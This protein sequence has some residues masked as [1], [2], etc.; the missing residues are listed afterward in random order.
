MWYFG[1]CVWLVRLVII[2]GCISMSASGIIFW[3]RVHSNE[4]MYTS[5][6][7]FMSKPIA[8]STL[9]NQQTR[10]K[11]MIRMGFPDSHNFLKRWPGGLAHCMEAFSITLWCCPIIVWQVRKVRQMTKPWPHFPYL[12]YGDKDNICFS[13]GCCKAFMQWAS[14]RHYYPELSSLKNCDYPFKAHSNQ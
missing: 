7:S 11:F 1:L 8:V 3:G 14:L 13:Q 12:P 9:H 5:T 10:V 2:S 4:Y 6:Y